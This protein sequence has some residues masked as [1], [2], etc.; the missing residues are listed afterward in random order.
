VSLHRSILDHWLY[1]EA[2]PF[3]V[4]AAWADLLL[5]ADWRTGVL[6]ENQRQLAD[7]WG[8]TQPR[9]YRFL[10]R[11][12]KDRMIQRCRVEYCLI[13]TKKVYRIG[14]PYHQAYRQEHRQPIHIAISNYWQYQ[15][16]RSTGK[17]PSV[18]AA[19]SAPCII[20]NKRD[21]YLFPSSISSLKNKHMSAVEDTQPQT[22][23]AY[24]E[25]NP[26]ALHLAS[27]LIATLKNTD[28]GD[29]PHKPKT[30]RDPAKGRK[31]WASTFRL[32]IND[33][34]D[35]EEIKETITWLFTTNLR[36][37][38]SFIVMSPASLRAKW[39]RIQIQMKRK[40]RYI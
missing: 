8:W 12:E 18:S 30:P 13:E 36:A 5:K 1:K 17:E 11:L 7:A 25:S 4:L 40:D 31:G 29:L 34:L 39:D 9:V 37:E 2:R 24:R 3:C 15:R 23:K 6:D 28:N 33:G 14:S 19:V 38:A 10:A 21:N 16:E 32:M 35:P 22:K 26:T 20:H 27:F